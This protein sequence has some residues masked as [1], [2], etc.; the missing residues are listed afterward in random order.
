MPPRS[1]QE[2]EIYHL[3]KPVF[4]WKLVGRMRVS[5]DWAVVNTWPIGGADYSYVFLLKKNQRLLLL[6][7]Q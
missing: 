1:F 6:M 3:Q 7:M 5:K 4:F 2:F